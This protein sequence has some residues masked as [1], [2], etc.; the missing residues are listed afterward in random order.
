MKKNNK[1][2]LIKTFLI[3]IVLFLTM[4]LNASTTQASDYKYKVLDP[5]FN[6][7]AHLLLEGKLPPERTMPQDNNKGFDF[8]TFLAIFALVTFPIGIVYIA[9]RTF[10]DVMT[11]Y[12][13][14]ANE[15]VI[16]NI[17]IRPLEEDIVLERNNVEKAC[18]V[19][20]TNIKSLKATDTKE[21]PTNFVKKYC[22]ETVEDSPNPMLLFTSQLAQNKGFCL[23]EYNQKYSLIGYVNDDIFLLNQFD[24]LKTTEIRSRLSETKS[25]SEMYIVRLGTYKSLVEVTDEKM[26][27]LIDL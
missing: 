24:S 10:K 6:P 8:G 20:I 9:V 27:L 15:Q 16:G 21:I 18:T 14:T 23:V 7:E 12:E 25:N 1:L 5:R 17:K 4:Y 22:E 11:P 26:E 19:P 3:C 13:D 2:S